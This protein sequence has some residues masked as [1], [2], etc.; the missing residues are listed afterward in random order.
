MIDATDA[1]PESPEAASLEPLRSSLRILVVDDDEGTREALRLVFSTS[2]HR[3][4]AVDTAELALV[5]VE[6]AY[7]DLV[8]LDLQLEATSGLDLLPK[9]LERSPWLKT[10]IITGFGSVESTVEAMRR[11]AWNYLTKPLDPGDLRLLAAHVQEIKDLERRVEDLETTA[12]PSAHGLLIE[13][14]NA[15]MRRAVEVA[16]QVADSDATVLILGESG[17]GKGVLARH[18]HEQ[19]R[20]RAGPFTVVSSPSLTAELMNSELFGHV[21]GAFTGAV[22]STAGK[23]A[24]AEGG[25]LFLDEV[26]DI[27]LA[28]Q[29]KLLRFLQDRQYER[30]GEAEVR[31]A[32][33]RVIAATNRDLGQAV[34]RGEFREDLFY[35]LDVIEITVPPL[36]ERREDIPTLARWFL[37]TYG[38]RYGK[39]DMEFTAKAERLLLDH[40]WPGNVRE[41]QNAVERAVILARTSQVG[42]N[43]LPRQTGGGVVDGLFSDDAQELPTL[44]G[45]EERYIRHVLETTASIEEASEV[46]DVAPSTLWRRRR[47][48]GI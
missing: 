13:S 29:P 32:D 2:D 42:A 14:G 20:R 36:R 39:P 48:Y 17:T 37:R 3:V 11:G 5:M 35:R 21:R 44:A 45:M 4:T 33:V 16:R 1:A 26:G 47:K 22:A 23:V 27:P 15:Q 31:E 30:V 8:F 38:H 41:L 25:S 40:P 24:A 28:I 6:R 19:S 34:E 9:L 18:I 10:V 7:F 46:L 43:L 12:G